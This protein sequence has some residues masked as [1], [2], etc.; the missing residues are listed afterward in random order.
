MRVQFASPT[1]PV[2]AAESIASVAHRSAAAPANSAVSVS[3]SAA[4][5]E[6]LA[7]DNASATQAA[8]PAANAGSA[9]FDTNHGTMTLDID[10]YFTPPGTQ[11]ADLDALPLLMPSQK[12][13]D[14]LSGHVSASMGQFL[15]ENGIPSPPASITYDNAGQIQLPAGYPY[16]DAFK[17]A[18]AEHPAMERELRTVAALSS[19]V[20]EMNKSLAFQE[21]YTTASSLAEVAA[22]VAKYRDLFSG[23]SHVDCI[24]LNFTDK[25]VLDI[26]HD[27]K[28][29]TEA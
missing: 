13:I 21:T 5:H 3:I 11:G 18:L 12:N 15:A 17:Q 22:T 4:A 25:G 6:R 8:M 26:T 1:Y 2:S 23:N 19:S 28:S 20:V 29:L 10:A 27:G 24:A 9:A 16:A 14:A 7:A